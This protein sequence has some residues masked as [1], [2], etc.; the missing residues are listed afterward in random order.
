M[1][2]R[3]CYTWK[4]K[5]GR[6]QAKCRW[7][8]RGDKDPDLAELETYSPIVSK[9]AWMMSMQ[10]NVSMGFDIELGDISSA[11]MNG[12]RYQRKQGP[13]YCELPADG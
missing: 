3:H 8:G 7:V 2:S 13:L 4:Q 12:Y 9:E 6:R 5:D 10:L 1:P 11:F